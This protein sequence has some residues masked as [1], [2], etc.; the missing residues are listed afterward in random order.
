MPAMG[1]VS[2]PRMLIIVPAYNESASLAATLASLKSLT[3]PHD[4]VV[5]SDGSTDATADIAR[6]G[7]AIVLDL[8][9]NMGVGAAMQ[10]GVR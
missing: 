7:G 6:A 5:V 1:T 9:C 10:A 4:V 3:L 2:S 8:A